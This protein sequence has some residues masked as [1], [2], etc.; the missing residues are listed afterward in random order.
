MDNKYWLVS[1]AKAVGGYKSV[2][3]PPVM[4]Q[5]VAYH[6]TDL[7]LKAGGPAAIN[8]A[9]EATTL[10][11][12]M[13]GLLPQ[14]KFIRDNIRPTDVLVVS[15]GGNDIALSPAPCTILNMLGL[16]CCTPKPCIERGCGVP[17]PCD[18]CCCGCGAG[19]CSTLLSCPPCGGY[20][21]HM[22]GPRVQKYIEALTSKTKPKHVL[23]CMIYYLD[24]RPGTSWADGALSLLGYNRD[25]KKLQM[26]IR[27]TYELATSRI[28]IPGVEV[29]PVPLFEALD[30]TR[31]EDYVA[32]VE[33]SAGG[34]RRMAELILKKVEGTRE[35]VY[36][37]TMKRS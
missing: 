13:Y 24:E 1:K 25:P 12:R 29:V 9:V 2:L 18:D 28:R 15:V 36:A 31:T 35:G 7:S 23:V 20:F 30:G 21:L 3:R 14:D 4:R 37:A 8:C 19:C 16:I 11:Q 34:G 26:L 6:L 10:N 33:P 32:R 5:D 17:L 27:K 22:F